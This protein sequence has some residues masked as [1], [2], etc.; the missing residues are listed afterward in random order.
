VALITLIVIFVSVKSVNH[1]HDK[2]NRNFQPQDQFN[3]LEGHLETDLKAEAISPPPTVV[4]AASE[5]ANTSGRA[6]ICIHNNMGFAY[7]FYT[8]NG[9]LGTRMGVSTK[10]DIKQTVCDGGGC[11]TLEILAGKPSGPVIWRPLIIL[12]WFSC[13]GN[14][15]HMISETLRPLAAT[16]NRIKPSEPPLVGIFASSPF[17]RWVQNTKGCH[18]PTYY[19]LMKLLGIDPVLFGFAHPNGGQDTSKNGMFYPPDN[20]R[21]DTTATYCFKDHQ[22]AHGST[23]VEKAILEEATCDGHE[24]NGVR[25][26]LIQRL[27]TRRIGNAQDLIA[28]AQSM[29][30]ITNATIVNLENLDIKDQIRHINCGNPIVVGVQGAGLE[31]TKFLKHTGRKAAVIELTWR[32]WGSYYAG[33]V[34]SDK[35][36]SKVLNTDVIWCPRPGSNSSCCKGPKEYAPDPS[37]KMPTKHMDLNVTITSWT[38]ALKQSIDFVAH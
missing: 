12:S 21:W 20:G 36:H 37:C 26:I 34:K 23:S 30:K 1:M 4:L 31:W 5:P 35:V 32:Q 28:I 3:D 27:N 22:I 14:I 29:P 17:S 9:F 13:E 19:P 11:R 25:V 18:G 38:S 2:S 15:H 33:N 16:L 7:T 6:H 10:S 24:L 8:H